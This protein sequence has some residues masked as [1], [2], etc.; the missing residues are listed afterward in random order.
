MS[1][2]R[3]KDVLNVQAELGEHPLWSAE[4]QCLY[5]LDIEH[6]TISRFVPGSGAN[7]AWRLP[8]R[9][10]CFALTPRGSAI[11]AAQDGLY[12]MDFQGSIERI[13][14]PAHD[15]AVMRFN[16]GRTDRQGR[17]WIS[18]VRADMDLS[19]TLDNA[20]YRFDGKSLDRMFGSIGIPNGTAFS[21]DGKN[22]YRAQTETRQIFRS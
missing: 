13:H 6:S 19:N 16:D 20:Y 21:P 5:W 10:G 4:G 15:P 1:S 14:L 7:T 11:I 9:P 3:P 22:L 8:A 18:T 2:Y 17:L 12:E